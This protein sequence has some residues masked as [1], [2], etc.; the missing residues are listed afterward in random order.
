MHSYTFDIGGSTLDCITFD[1]ITQRIVSCSHKESLEYRQKSPKDWCDDFGILSEVCRFGKINITGGKNTLIPDFFVHDHSQ[2]E[3][4]K[5]HEFKS[6]AKG[7]QFLSGQKE[8]LAVSLGTGTAMVQFCGDEWE[9]VKGTGI[10]GGS[11]I[12]LGKALLGM[13]SF[14]DIACLAENGS[15][16][17]INLSVGD[18]V[19]GGIGKLS[20]EMTASHFAKYS[21][22]S[23]PQDIAFGIASLVAESIT[24]LAIEK[25]LRIGTDTI[26]VGGKFSQLSILQDQMKT[27]GEKYNTTVLFPRYSTY[28]TGVGASLL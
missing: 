28:M 17:N 6:L 3:I 2:V 8:G 16:R 21:G 24:S 25:A 5:H 18:I 15:A 14:W 19:G 12:G 26:V 20:P 9:H 1:L 13:D 7:A 23:V 10:G 27:L 22:D 4:R 11:F